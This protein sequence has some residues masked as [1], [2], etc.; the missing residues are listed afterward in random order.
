MRGVAPLAV[1]AGVLHALAMRGSKPDTNARS[2]NLRRT[3]T[4]AEDFLWSALRNRSL[5]GYKF[6]RQAPIGK[7]FADFLCRE[8]MLI[9]EADGSQHQGNAHDEIRDA[10]LLAQGYSVICFNNTDIM[11]GRHAVL[12]TIVEALENRLEAQD[13]VGMK[14]KRPSRG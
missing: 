3:S 4:D 9:V 14:F 2:R 10:W 12:D 5:N 6:I 8:Q 7:Y 11:A 13:S 1:L